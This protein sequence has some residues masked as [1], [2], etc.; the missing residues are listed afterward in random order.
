MES[1]TKNSKML[2]E[3]TKDR[4]KIEY[5]DM[6]EDAHKNQLWFKAKGFNLYLSP[7]ELEEA[8]KNGK[9]LFPANYFQLI[10]PNEYLKPHSKKLYNA[11]L[12]YDY[13]HK[14][15]QVYVQRLDKL[16]NNK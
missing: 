9:H 16:T 4:A 1:K 12:M 11:Q 13:A 5:K 7:Y 10:N 14:R 8:H 15:L 3:L 6:L 2:R